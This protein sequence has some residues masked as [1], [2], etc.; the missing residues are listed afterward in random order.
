MEEEKANR[1]RNG[2]GDNAYWNRPTGGKARK[3]PTK[4]QLGLKIKAS[5]RSDMT[6]GPR[7][8]S[9]SPS[10]TLSHVSLSKVVSQADPDVFRR[11]KVSP[12]K[13]QPTPPMDTEE[14]RDSKDEKAIVKLM[15][16]TLPQFSN[17]AD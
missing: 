4:Y 11:P 7:T 6:T 5:N 3:V 16:S 12:T 10:P 8:K 2:F 13:G 9:R 14:E 17:E 15:K 1:D